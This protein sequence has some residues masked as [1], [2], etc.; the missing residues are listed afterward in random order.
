MNLSS[1]HQFTKTILLS[2]FFGG[3]LGGAVSAFWKGYLES[4]DFWILI[5]KLSLF[6]TAIAFVAIVAFRHYLYELAKNDGECM[7]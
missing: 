6:E 2:F 3:I 7:V 5:L 1:S 4:A